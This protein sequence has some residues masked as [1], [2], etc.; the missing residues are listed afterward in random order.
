MHKQK[1]FSSLQWVQAASSFCRVVVTVCGFTA[2]RQDNWIITQ[3]I[4]RMVN[5]SALQQVT[6][7]LDFQLGACIST[8][9]CRQSFA[10][11]KYET[12]I[13]NATAA[14][15][16]SNF[17]FVGQI[18]PKAGSGTVRQNASVNLN[19]A[20]EST[21][22]YLGIQDV[23]SCII[24]RRVLV[25]YYMCPAV[26]SDLVTHPE[27][28]APIIGGTTP[29]VQVVGTCVENAHPENGTWARLTCSQNGVW[30]G[31]SCVCNP[32][33]KPSSDGRSCEGMLS[34]C[35]SACLPVYPHSY[36]SSLYPPSEGCDPGMYLA[37]DDACLPCPA[38]SNSTQSGV[39]VCP[40]FEGYYRA[41][42]EPLEMNCTRKYCTH[43]H[44]LLLYNVNKS[45]L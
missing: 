10:I 19:F 28:I 11:H 29:P 44:A 33:F 35:L 9:N 15:N 13:I 6:V 25:F 12:S 45:L 1:L 36:I 39:S 24:I 20:T 31:A 14:R 41:N 22:F 43:R 30:S 5:G 18:A 27:T 4:S 42:R 40:C 37:M 26:T 34:V 7:Q 8:S 32:G 23:S 2:G 17:E 3:H 16:L 21:G 38:N